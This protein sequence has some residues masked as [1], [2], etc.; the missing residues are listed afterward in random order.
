MK[1]F[2][3]PLSLF[4]VIGISASQLISQTITTASDNG[5][6][7]SEGWGNGSNG[8]TGFQAWNIWSSNG[9]GGSG[10]NFIGNPVSGGVTGMAANSFSLYANPN[11]SGAYANGERRLNTSLAIGQTLSFQWSI[12]YDSGTGGNKGFSLYS[13]GEEILYINNAGSADI[14]CNG[15]NVGFA[16]GT[17]AMIWSFTR[18]DATTISVTANG[19]NGTN[20]FSTNIVAA[21][22]AIDRVKFYASAMQ[23]GDE[24][25]PYFN[26]LTVTEP[27]A[28]SMAVPG[29]HAFLG[30]WSPNGSNGTGMTKSS[31]PAT[32]NLWTSYFKSS[33]ARLISVKFVAHGNFDFA[34]GADPGRAG[35]A[36][37]GGDSIKLNIPATG[38]YKFSFDQSTLQYSLTRAGSADFGSYEVFLD[39]YGLDGGEAADDDGDGLTNG[40]EYVRNTDPAN[41]DSDAD[42]INDG[43]EVITTNTNPL[44]ADSDTDTLPDWWEVARGLNPNSSAG[45]DGASGDPDGD[46]FTNKQEFEG[47]SNPLSATSV[48]ANRLVA[49]T[50]DLNRQI[51]AGSF[52]TSGSAVEVWG[53]FN[54]WGNFTN[55]YSLTNNG[56]GIYSGTFVVPGANGA[57]SRYKFVTFDG[58][59]TLS[60][61]SGSDRVLVMG[62]NGQPISLPVA[63]LGEVRPVTFSVNMGVQVALGR[64]VHGTNKVYLVGDVVGSW[65]VPGTE[66]A[67]VGSSDVYSAEVLVAGSQNATANYKFYANNSLAFETDLDAST[68]G[69]QTRVLILGARDTA[70]TL[71]VAYFNN[72]DVVPSNRTVTFAVDMGVQAF[73]GAF[74]PGTDSVYLM[75]DVSNWVTGVV[76]TREGETSIYKATLNLEGAENVT[77]NY[78]FK[79]SN[80]AVGNAGFEGDMDAGISGDTPRVLRLG[81]ASVPQPLTTS[82]FNNQSEAR[83]ITVRVDMSIQQQ[84]G[85]FNPSTGTV[86][87]GGN[88]NGWTAASLVAQGNGIYAG[89]FLVEVPLSAVEYKFMNGV[90]YESISNRTITVAL[91]NLAAS[92][93]DPVYFNNHDVAVAD[94]TF[95][96]AYPD[97]SMTE[98]A[99]NGLTYLANYAFGGDS[100]T[101]PI[102][103][104]QDMS[105]PNKLQLIVVYRTDDPTL[106][107]S[108]LRGEATTNL[109]GAWDLPGV[110]VTD[111]DITGLPSKLTR[112][113]I[114]VDRGSD[115]K[116]FLRATVTK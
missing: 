68:A 70:E 53:T 26:N 21:G 76:M 18:T 64:F 88:F 67:R 58:N 8:G 10:G 42:T 32:P 79:S 92:K 37:R 73:R 87:V 66:L 80:T 61:E 12:N 94:S 24:A 9:T 100:N 27:V 40:Q 59:N 81:A 77:L 13:G 28:T 11:G 3:T 1:R 69:D 29:D 106:P 55:K 95:A 45:N 57:T 15:G 52:S 49:F 111:G 60:W 35:Y 90:T 89:E 25:Q 36:K 112:K 99:P 22:G 54:D 116:K 14:T 17:N 39:T 101:Q 93:L 96:D 33:D 110:T 31:N 48:P 4:F 56:S 82:T 5:A 75:G 43:I 103:P 65:N 102:L 46:N 83:K 114:S 78:K 107:L 105:D 2:S 91:P 104:V 86:K 113:V 6:N 30:A 85:N 71:P 38:L 97:K 47:Q 51:T 115:P 84:A 50:L 109:T 63:Y 62:A 108:G 98:V 41:V 44:S 20:S 16:Y 72:V 7:Y 34:W 23:R 19:R 74:T